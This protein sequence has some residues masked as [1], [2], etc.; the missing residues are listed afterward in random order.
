MKRYYICD[1][2]GTGDPEDPFRAAVA[3][4]G[5]NYVAEIKS[6]PVTGLPLAPWALVCVATKNHSP[7]LNR[8]G[9]DAM[10][11]FPL[12]GKVSAIQTATKNAMLERMQARGIDIS[13]VGNADGFRDVIRGVGRLLNDNFNENNFDVSE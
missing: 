13:F 1:I 2:L 10:P 9:L 3:E 12:D 4:L 8:P 11:D 7:L 6:D 5:V